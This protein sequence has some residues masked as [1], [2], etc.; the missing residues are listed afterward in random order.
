M[1]PHRPAARQGFTLIELLVV[2]S[3]IALLIGLLLPALQQAREF[4]RATGCLSNLRQIGFAATAYINDNN[5]VPREAASIPG[6]DI[7]WALAF[8][9]YFSKIKDD[10]FESVPMYRCPDHPNKAHWLHFVINAFNFSRPGQVYGDRREEHKPNLIYFPS[11]TIYMA[12]FTDDSQNILVNAWYP[13]GQNTHENNVVI[14]YDIWAAVHVQRPIEGQQNGLR[15]EPR[16]H[17]GGSNALFL[18]GHAARLPEEDMQNL[19]NWDDRTYL[20]GNVNDYERNR[21]R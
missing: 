9:P 6:R 13:Q 15:L 19:D 17:V 12:D 5:L 2:I 11:Q 7:A 4:G 10:R 18:D 8:R 3:I 16:R 20:R 1:R 21:Y 14:W